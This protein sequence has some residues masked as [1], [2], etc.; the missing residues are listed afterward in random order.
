MSARAVAHL[1]LTDHARLPETAMH[2]VAPLLQAFGDQVAG[3]ELLVSQLRLRM[4]AAAQR[5][6][7]VFEFGDARRNGH[8]VHV[9]S[10][11]MKA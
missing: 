7:F 10:P 8:G 5:D 6:H 9:S 2:R 4:D 3:G 1:Q 11:S